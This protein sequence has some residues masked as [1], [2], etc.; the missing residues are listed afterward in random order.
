M[1]ND[2]FENLISALKSAQLRGSEKNALLQNIKLAMRGG[3]PP[4]SE[5]KKLFGF[6]L[7]SLFINKYAFAGSAVLLVVLSSAGVSF[8]AE[9]TLPGD[10]LYPVKI[11]VNERIKAALAP[12]PQ[13]RAKIETDITV[14]RL[15]EA[16]ALSAKGKLDA[17]KTDQ[18]IQNLQEHSDR[19]QKNISDVRENISAKAALQLD[20]QL[21]ASLESHLPILGK[22]S[23]SEDQH[24]HPDKQKPQDSGMLPS[25]QNKADKAAEDSHQAIKEL[26]QR[27]QDFQKD[28]QKEKLHQGNGDNK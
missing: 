10:F 25:Q 17:Q 9:N 2:K 8:A 23:E 12:S 6:S 14:A 1:N 16:E 24:D 20:N 4:K 5:A 18:I 26:E 19:L 21:G 3:L 22:L 7:R 27:A 28:F 15:K 13:A 11:N